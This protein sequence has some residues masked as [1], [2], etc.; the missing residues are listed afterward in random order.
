[1][2]APGKAWWHTQ[3]GTYSAWLPGDERGFRSKGHRIHSSGHYKRPAPPEEHKGL[4]EYHR[5]R[6]PEPV[7]IPREVRLRVA[8]AMAETLTRLGHVV[9]VIAVAEKHAHI[10]S[11]L[12]TD[13]RAYNRAVGK[14]KCDSSRAIRKMLPGRVWARDDRHDLIGDRAYRGNAVRYVRN[15]QGPCAAVWCCDGLR[16]EASR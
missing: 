6:H 10:V 15:R 1:M 9:L 16:R 5:R 8:T 13:E 4:R 2:P 3:I 14:A 12:P 7:R 11:E